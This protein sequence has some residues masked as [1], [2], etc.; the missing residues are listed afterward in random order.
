MPGFKYLQ[1]QQIRSPAAAELGA[2]K[3]LPW[4][5]CEC[6]RSYL[7][8]QSVD[9]SQAKLKLRYCMT[10]SPSSASEL[11][12]QSACQAWG[13]TCP[14]RCGSGGCLAQT[15]CV[16]LETCRAWQSELQPICGRAHSPAF[17]SWLPAASS[18]LPQASWSGNQI[19]PCTKRTQSKGLQKLLLHVMP[20]H[21]EFPRKCATS[22]SYFAAKTSIGRY[23]RSP[24][25]NPQIQN[26]HD[27]PASGQE[28]QRQPSQAVGHQQA[29][30]LSNIAHPSVL[31][32]GLSTLL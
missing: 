13:A 21:W 25:L 24:V 18:L 31:H 9:Q 8:F 12:M 27:R 19:G 10:A 17:P 6:L 30:P 23:A 16:Y 1:T 2:Y 26:L 3:L 28:Y 20:F 32:D 5:G 7:L 14:L 15:N 11:M 4:L 29:R 22:T